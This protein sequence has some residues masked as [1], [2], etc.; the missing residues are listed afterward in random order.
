MLYD[1][2]SGQRLFAKAA[3][4]HA[5]AKSEMS[6]AQIKTLSAEVESR[7]REGPNGIDV[8]EADD[9]RDDAMLESLA[10]T[11]AMVLRAFLAVNRRT[12]AARASHGSCSR[13]ARRTAHGARRRR[14]AGRCSP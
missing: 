14:T 13:F 12:R 8:D 4:L 5:M 11:L 3:L 1:A 6:A 7:L 9:D 2:R 10:R